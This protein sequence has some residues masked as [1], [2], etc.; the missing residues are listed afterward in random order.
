[1]LVGLWTFLCKGE[2]TSSLQCHNFVAFVRPEETGRMV[3]VTRGL[4]YSRHECE[5]PLFPLLTWDDRISTRSNYYSSCSSQV[6]LLPTP[7]SPCLSAGHK[8]SL[9]AMS[10]DQTRS[11]ISQTMISSFEFDFPQNTPRDPH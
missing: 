1:M 5:Q 6:V 7:G 2:E 9:P 11:V 3:A 4:F 10:V 8:P